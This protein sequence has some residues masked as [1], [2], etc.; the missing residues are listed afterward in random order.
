MRRLCEEYK[1]GLLCVDCAKHGPDHSKTNAEA[2]RRFAAASEEACCL[3][4]ERKK[5]FLCVGV[6]LKCLQCL[7]VKNAMPERCDP[8]AGEVEP[9][10]NAMKAEEDQDDGEVRRRIKKAKGWLKSR[11]ACRTCDEFSI[12][13]RVAVSTSF[14]CKRC[15]LPNGFEHG[16]KCEQKRIIPL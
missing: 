14:C 7:D 2:R 9:A 16:W 4:A 1:K 15:E 6:K 8:A 12:H 13:S 11:F 5:G 3:S 10:K